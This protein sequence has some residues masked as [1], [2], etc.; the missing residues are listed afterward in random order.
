MTGTLT[1]MTATCLICAGEVGDAELGR[2]RVWDD[3]LWR[4]STS[5]VAPVSG[6]SYIEPKRHI[7]YIT[8]L[9]GDEAQTLG[10][11][12][13]V[14]SRAIK[15]ITGA[16][17]IYVNVFGQ[18]IAHLHF[19]LAPHT[20]GGPLRGGAG[21]IDAKAPPLPAEDLTRVAFE[22]G[23]RLDTVLASD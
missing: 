8:D 10:H 5:L 7:P 4:V 16:E 18:R 20:T 23:R 22:I 11:V 2:V 12:L 19:N 14:T 13:S 6:F 9:D 1:V 21:M 17:Y 15:A 3:K